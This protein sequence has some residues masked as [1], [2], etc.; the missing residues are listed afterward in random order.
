VAGETA[1]ADGRLP[2]VVIVGAG[3]GGLEVARQLGGAPARVSVIDRRNYHLFVPLLYQVATA[4]LSPGD[5]AAP[6]RAVLAKHDNVDVLLGDVSDVDVEAKRVDFDG[7]EIDYDVLVL[8]PGSGQS[9]FGHDEWADYA[10]GLKTIED[11]RNIRGRLLMAF[12]RAE[13]TS[14]A[15]E[16]RRLMTV[17]LVGGGP[18][19]VEMAGAVAELAKQ[20]LRREFRRIRPENARVILLEAMPRLLGPFP[21]RLAGF[22]ERKLERLGCETRTGAMVETIDE[23]G[24]VAGGERIETATVIWTAGVQAAPVGRWLGVETEKTG[25]IKV[26]EHLAVPGLEDVYVIGDAALAL[27]ENGEPLP[28]LAQVAKQQGRYLGKA[29]RARFAGRPR[30]APF[31]FKNYG[32]MATIGRNAAIADFGWWRTA[33]FFAWLLWGVVHIYLLIGFRNRVV[34]A[35]EWLWAYVTMQRGARL[36]TGKRKAPMV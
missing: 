17:V 15:E 26:D 21:E 34:V 19:G 18:T 23:R 28:G 9:Y 30:S 5:I 8:A 13:M 10:P 31:R 22:A 14:D 2:R 24:V 35:I 4:A 7:Y 25:Q 12:E 33:G 11:A 16:Q 32:N 36:I 1:T 29:L 6:I 20:T 27:D 3:F